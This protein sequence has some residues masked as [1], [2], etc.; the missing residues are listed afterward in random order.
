MRM[1]LALALM[2]VSVSAMAANK[3][4]QVIEESHVE[5]ANGYYTL[6]GVCIAS[7][8]YSAMKAYEFCSDNAGTIN[9]LSTDNVMMSASCSPDVS[10]SCSDYNAYILRTRMSVF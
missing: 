10:N 3:K 6:K 8:D 4:V 2:L 1:F 9:M 7:T 5:L